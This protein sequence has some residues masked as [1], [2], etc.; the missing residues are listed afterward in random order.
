MATPPPPSSG[1]GRARLPVAASQEQ[2]WSSNLF[3]LRFVLFCLLLSAPLG[4]QPETTFVQM[5]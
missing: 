5:A 3:G 1:S 2:C 4:Q